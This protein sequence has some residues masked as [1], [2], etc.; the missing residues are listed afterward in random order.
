MQRALV[1]LGPRRPQV[2]QALGEM[3]RVV[4]PHIKSLAFGYE[5]AASLGKNVNARQHA[6][7]KS[8]PP[9]GRLYS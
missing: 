2:S 3:T 6:Q 1:V 8:L 5:S 9:V 7:A 4:G